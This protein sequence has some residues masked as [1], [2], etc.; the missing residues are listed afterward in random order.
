MRRSAPPPPARDWLLHI[1]VVVVGR[2]A[3]GAV[4]RENCVKIEACFWA[5]LLGMVCYK[6]VSGTEV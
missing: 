2:V 3:S 1:T 4:S 6:F 5:N